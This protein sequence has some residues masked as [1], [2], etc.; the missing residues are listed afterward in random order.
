MKE[1]QIKGGKELVEL[2]QAI[3]FISNKFDEYEKIVKKRKKELR[4]W[5]TA[6]LT[7]QSE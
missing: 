1:G 2:M 3:D 4:Y 6:Q 7:S 5:E